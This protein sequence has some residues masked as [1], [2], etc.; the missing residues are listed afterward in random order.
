MVG[1]ID[2]AS[3]IEKLVNARRKYGCSRDEV[4][5]VL[6]VVLLSVWVIA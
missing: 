1:K 3:S 5:G 2:E 6:K 4:H